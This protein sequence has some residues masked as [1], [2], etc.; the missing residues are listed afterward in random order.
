MRGLNTPDCRQIRAC[1]HHWWSACVNCPRTQ[2][3][4]SSTAW[5]CVIGQGFPNFSA[6]GPQNNGARDW[7]P[8]WTLEEAYNVV[9][10]CAKSLLGLHGHQYNTKEQQPNHHNII[11]KYFK[12][13]YN[14][15]LY[16]N[17]LNMQ[18]YIF[19]LICFLEGISQPPSL[20]LMTP[21]GV[22]APTLGTTA[23]GYSSLHRMQW[24]HCCHQKE[25]MWFL[26][27]VD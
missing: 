1:S 2:S 19:L 13:E 26:C 9:H 14:Q 17:G 16:I 11:F 27:R 10:S 3:V 7:G 18:L 25:T 6:R 21:W 22:L 4:S 23:V 5:W 12:K 8:L 20:C 24:M 15:N